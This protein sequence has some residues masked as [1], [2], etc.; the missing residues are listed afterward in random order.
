[1]ELSGFR[2]VLQTLADHD[3]EFIVVGGVAA[4]LTGAPVNTFDLD[5]GNPRI[6]SACWQP[7]GNWMPATGIGRSFGRMNRTSPPKAISC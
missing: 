7:S 5:V 6:Y 2:A 1:M 3:V 4:V